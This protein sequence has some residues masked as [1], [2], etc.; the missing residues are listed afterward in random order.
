[1][2]NRR[3][4]LLT[5]PARAPTILAMKASAMKATATEARVFVYGSINTDLVAYVERLPRP[6]ET[7]SGGTYASFP[8]GKGANQAVAAARAG[9]R[10]EMHACL[11]ND[12]FG[13]E[14]LESLAA[15]GVSTEH[16]RLL[17]GIHTGIALITVDAKGENTIA[18]AP[19]ANTRFTADG[20]EVPRAP[21]GRGSTPPQGR[22]STPPAG[23]GP[24]WVSL[25][26]NEVPLPATEALIARARAA[27]HI[28]VWNAAPGLRSRPSR[29]TLAS[30]DTL[31]CNTSELEGL[32]GP[33]GDVEEAARAILGQGVRSVVVT[34]GGKG[35]LCVG[36]QGVMRQPAFPVQAVDTVGAGDCFSGVFAAALAQGAE[37]PAALRM[38]S[39]AAAI[40]VTRKGAQP[41]MPS[42]GEIEDF[43]KSRPA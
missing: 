2:F 24:K 10:V 11:G 16:I 37:L 33:H 19:G 22:G 25:L 13:R 12:G 27:G 32:A 26:Q 39:A 21:E 29:E 41:S 31:I 35:C 18:A 34:L 9:V 3:H 36:P 14:R 42:R 1:M 23:A 38:A 17:D 30:V 7:I 4:A 43:L 6:G 40:S 5:R 15:A 8:G 20:I 28:V